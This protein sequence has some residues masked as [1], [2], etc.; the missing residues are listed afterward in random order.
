MTASDA[1][2]TR[3]EAGLPASLAKCMRGYFDRHV[4]DAL[5]ERLAHAG[6]DALRSALQRPDERASAIDLLA[7]DA[8]LTAAFEAAAE[9]GA[10][11]VDR[12]AAATAPAAFAELLTEQP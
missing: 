3:R 2:L 8:L 4:S 1:W 9:E 5:P 6:L 7:A 12:L 11:V 10:A